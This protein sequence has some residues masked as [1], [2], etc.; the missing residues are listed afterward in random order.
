V[1]GKVGAASRSGGCGLMGESGK[2]R[3]TLVF[4]AK[5]KE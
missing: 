2:R 5:Q 4:N 1:R 3:L